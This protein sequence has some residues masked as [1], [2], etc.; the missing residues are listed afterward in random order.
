[1]L[2]TVIIPHQLKL[3]GPLPGPYRPISLIPAIS[4]VFEKVGIYAT[5]HLLPSQQVILHILDKA[6]N[7]GSSFQ[8]G[9]I[10]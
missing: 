9:L 10:E 2:K 8:T 1:M 7:K 5:V 6:A 3:P 4:N